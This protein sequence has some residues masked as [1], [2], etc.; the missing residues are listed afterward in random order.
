MQHVDVGAVD[1]LD[2]A[3]SRVGAQRLRAI[4]PGH[5]HPVAGLDGVDQVSVAVKRDRVRGLARR[6][7][8]GC[9]L[10]LY[11]L[12]AWDHCGQKHRS[13]WVRISVFYGCTH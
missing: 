13:V 6:H 1:R 10:K 3:R 2:V 11:E 5:D 9:F 4:D 7:V 8:V 12:S